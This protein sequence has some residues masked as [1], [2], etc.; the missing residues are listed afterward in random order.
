MGKAKPKERAL[1]RSFGCLGHWYVVGMGVKEI[2]E[3]E[4]AKERTLGLHQG[5]GDQ[6]KCN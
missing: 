3:E 4:K 1:G 5:R 6:R 2:V